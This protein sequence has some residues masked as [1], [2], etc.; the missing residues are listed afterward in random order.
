MTKDEIRLKLIE[1]KR[2]ALN[3]LDDKMYDMH[4]WNIDR[5]LEREEVNWGYIASLAIDLDYLQA[6]QKELNDIIDEV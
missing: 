6:I 2:G 3:N 5:E 4:T 1:L